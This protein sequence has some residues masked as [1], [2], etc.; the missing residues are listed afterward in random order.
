MGIDNLSYSYKSN[1]LNKKK[2]FFFDIS[3]KK[4]VNI[5]NKFQPHTVI[6]AAASSYVVEAEKNK[7]KYYLNNVTKTKIFI[8]SCNDH[9]IEN[10]I[11]LSSSNVYNENNRKISV[12]ENKITKPKNYYGKNKLIIKKYLKKKTFKKLIILRLFNIIG[13]SNKAFKPF[14]FKKE[15]YQRLIFKIIQNFKKNRQT[16]INY[17]LKKNKKYFHLEIL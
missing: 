11:F 2:H 16:N 17:V 14:I 13:I 9:K 7:K 4:L 6:H 1:I 15:N 10:F 8:D 5:L 3:N 12:K